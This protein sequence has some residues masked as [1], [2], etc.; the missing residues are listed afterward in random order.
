MRGRLQL[1][2]G[3]SF[4]VSCTSRY[5]NVSIRFWKTGNGKKYPTPEGI[6]FKFSEWEDFIKVAQKMYSEYT[7]IYSCESC[8]LDEDRTGHDIN[9]YEECKTA[10]ETFCRGEVKE[11]IPL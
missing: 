11:D 9:T 3:S 6:S 2:L 10:Q 1:S 8:I 4:Y 5:R 7:E